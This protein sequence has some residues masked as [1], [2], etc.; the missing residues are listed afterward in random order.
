M[1]IPKMASF[2]LAITIIISFSLCFLMLETE[3]AASSSEKVNLTVYYESLS[4]PCAEFI[5][6]NLVEVFNRDLSDILSLQLV[7]WANASINS[8]NNSISCQ[9]GLDE[10]NLNSLESCI[11]NLSDD[12]SKNY[13]L[14]YCFEFLVIEGRLKQ[15]ES[16]FSELDLPQK[17]VLKCY[18]QGNGTQPGRKYVNETANL[19]PSHK[20]L[21]WVV[22]N[23]QPIGKDYANFTT[24]VCRAYNGP[25]LPAACNKQQ[26]N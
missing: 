26:S 5:I 22:V 12:V 3:A 7:P 11:L 16:C 1:E 2:K 14:I 4:K 24:Y 21:P 23:N 19:R 25:A 9:N 18:N 6:R 8:T 17:P 10:C 15:W 20:F 13:A